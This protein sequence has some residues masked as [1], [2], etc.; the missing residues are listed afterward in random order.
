M[1]CLPESSTLTGL[2]R[3][4]GAAALFVFLTATAGARLVSSDLCARADSNRLF[5]RRL[6]T[7][8]ALGGNF[9]NRLALHLLLGNNRQNHAYSIAAN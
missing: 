2:V 5:R 3:Y 7:V 4:I 9:S 6:T 1:L 8:K